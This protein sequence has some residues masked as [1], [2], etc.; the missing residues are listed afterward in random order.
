[1][2]GISIHKALASLDLFDFLI[3]H[4]PYISI[5]KALA[6]LDYIH[7]CDDCGFRI[8]IH[9]ALASLDVFMWTWLALL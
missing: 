2:E 8:S 9:K 3:E 1:M 6:S 4:G 5:H 7:G